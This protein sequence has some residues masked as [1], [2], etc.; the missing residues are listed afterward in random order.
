MLTLF[1]LGAHAVSAVRAILLSPSNYRGLSAFFSVYFP[2]C[3]PR[4]LMPLH[5]PK[6]TQAGY[7][8]HPPITI[9]KETG[10]ELVVQAK[11]HEMCTAR[12]T[13]IFHV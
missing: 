13:A 11:P 6:I 1:H 8:F 4:L 3:L 2:P 5:I 9:S 7:W 12:P 10:V